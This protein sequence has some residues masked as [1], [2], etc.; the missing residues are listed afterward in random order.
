MSG[1]LSKPDA[2][3]SPPARFFAVLAGII[4]GLAL[5]K[6][7]TP[8]IFERRLPAP[9]NWLEILF[10]SWP[11]AWGLWLLGTLALAGAGLRLAARFGRPPGSTPWVAPAPDEVKAGS[12][13]RWWRV[14]LW[15]PLAWFLWQGVSATQTLDPGLSREALWHFAACITCFY[16]GLFVLGRLRRQPEFLAGLLLALAVV[17]AAGWDQRF[18]GL[19]DTRRR[20]EKIDWSQMPPEMAARLNTQEF[21]ARMASDRIFSTFVYP[22]ALAGAILLLLPL[23]IQSGWR[24]GCWRFS[25]SKAAWLAAGAVAAAGLG[26]LYWSGSKAG[27]LIAL[28]AGLAAWLS[29]RFSTRLKWFAAIALLAA[30]LA[31]FLWKFSAYFSE[32]R[33]ASVSARFAYWR[34]A[35]RVAADRPWVGT[36]P[37]TFILPYRQ[38]KP[39]EAEMTR[40][41]HN[42]YLQQAS[43]SGWPAFFLYAAFIAGSLWRL[44][45]AGGAAHPDFGLW[46]GLAAWALHGLVEFGLY[47]P[48]ESW[49]FFLLL[50]ALWS[51]QRHPGAGG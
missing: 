29:S 9:S 24:W 45:P 8:V 42:D 16:L 20:Y 7:G 37:G 26:C 14:L 15:L 48:A 41:V 47:I 22:N 46:L 49:I 25:S 10:Y 18:G 28:L 1:N 40:L 35:A 11:L 27:W 21:R 30:G 2:A 5:L 6:L 34:V 19:E 4:F 33:A 31:G 50:G 32:R 39:P 3:V 51:E 38:M 43:D 12:S 36:G 17:L 44:R 23:A 13:R